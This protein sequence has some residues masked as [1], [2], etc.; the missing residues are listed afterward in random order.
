MCVAGLC[1]DYSVTCPDLVYG[2]TSTITGTVD[3]S[4][5]NTCKTFGGDVEVDKAYFHIFPPHNRYSGT[6]ICTLPFPACNSSAIVENNGHRCSCEK[7][8]GSLW[9]YKLEF[10]FDEA[11][12]KGHDLEL[13]TNCIPGSHTFSS[14]MC[15]DLNSEYIPRIKCFKPVIK[16]V[17]KSALSSRFANLIVFLCIPLVLNAQSIAKDHLKAVLL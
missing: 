17:W 1:A 11:L 8:D 14:T 6:N 16:T 10:F 12:Y 13:T 5:F 15:E 7:H 9:H 3:D 2:K 4:H